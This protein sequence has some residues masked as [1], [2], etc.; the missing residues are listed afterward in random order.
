MSQSTECLRRYRC[1]DDMWRSSITTRALAQILHA[2]LEYRH[3]IMTLG[4]CSWSL[5]VAMWEFPEIGG[6]DFRILQR[7][8]CEDPQCWPWGPLAL[9]MLYESFDSKRLSARCPNCLHLLACGMHLGNDKIK[10]A[11]VLGQLYAHGCLALCIGGRIPAIRMSVWQSL[12]FSQALPQH[13][14]HTATTNTYQ[15]Q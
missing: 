5:W 7:F 10:S 9:R 15:F 2:A 14:L 1:L 13:W 6:S 12:E 4:P 11:H 3:D 8:S